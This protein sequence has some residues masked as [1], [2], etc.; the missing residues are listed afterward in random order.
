MP[1]GPS[2][3]PLVI[4]GPV[5]SGPVISGPVTS[6]PVTSGPVISGPVISGPVTSGPVTS[7][8]V[9]SGPSVP[10]PPGSPPNG[11]PSLGPIG[12][13][14]SL[15]FTK[16]STSFISCS[17][18]AVFSAVWFV[19]DSV[20]PV[21]VMVPRLSGIFWLVAVSEVWLVKAA[22]IDDGAW[23][24]AVTIGVWIGFAVSEI[25]L[26]VIFSKKVLAAVV[27]LSADV[28]LIGPF[29][30]VSAPV[31]IS[32]TVLSVMLPIAPPPPPAV[33][34][35]LEVTLKVGLKVKLPLP[36]PPP[37]K[38]PKPPGPPEPLGPLG[39]EPLP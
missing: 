33:F 20:C 36:K 16:L 37:P 34:T 14:C 39:A 8:P 30:V 3:G 22:A 5:I 15:S 21:L 18:V 12:K 19:V 31:S 29:V 24:D 17:E 10:P 38:P 26:S 7:G 27:P 35:L 4:S 6:G 1:L 23:F 32:P 9:T 28:V 13:F 25:T 2:C 11:F